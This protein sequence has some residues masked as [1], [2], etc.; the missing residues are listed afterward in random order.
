MR[1]LIAD[2][3]PSSRLL[4]KRQLATLG[5]QTDEADN[6]EAALQR[7]CQGNYDLLITD[8]NMPLMN[9]LE[10]T[11]EI[12]KFNRVLTIWGLTA[13]AQEHE[14]ERCLAAGMDACLF[15]PI[16]L[17]QLSRL[18]SGVND[19]GDAMFDIERLALLAQGNRQLMATAL[20][21]AQRENRRDLA[22]A[23]QCAGSADL[24]TIK[25]HI[26][27]I[28]GT[29]QLLGVTSLMVAAQSLEEKLTAAISPTEV[30]GELARIASLL[31]EL[32]RAIE[33]FIP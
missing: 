31:D 22:A 6:G 10:L 8:L 30:A 16:T 19:T 2:D 25:H 4:L 13:T 18:L 17:T 15:K 24:Q 21:D 23:R 32:D 12:R 3:H 14:R 27:R 7:L 33:R 9:G 11:R 29:A 1:V 5:I 26:H 20:K 28:N